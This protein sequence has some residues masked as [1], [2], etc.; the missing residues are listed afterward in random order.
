MRRRDSQLIQT[1][2]EQKLNLKILPRDDE[3]KPPF[4]AKKQKKGN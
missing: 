4:N 3:E 2:H 1:I